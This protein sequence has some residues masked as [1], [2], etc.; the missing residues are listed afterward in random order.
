MT[1]RRE[2]LKPLVVSVASALVSVDR[3]YAAIPDRTLEIA[4]VAFAEGDYQ[5]AAQLYAGLDAHASTPSHPLPR[6]W[7]V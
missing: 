5:L 4:R 1:E 2:G 7:M 6:D 3:G